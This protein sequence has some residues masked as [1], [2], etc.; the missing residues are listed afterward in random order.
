MHITLDQVFYLN[1]RIGSTVYAINTLNQ[2]EAASVPKRYI[3]EHHIDDM[4]DTKGNLTPRA[5]R[6]AHELL[7]QPKD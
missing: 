3:R 2:L 1:K 7:T 6:F 5:I 4:I